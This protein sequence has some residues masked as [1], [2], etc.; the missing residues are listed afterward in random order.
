MF[1]G[2]A[3]RVVG[4]SREHS[5]L[6]DDI[7]RELEDQDKLDQ[8]TFRVLGTW[9]VDDRLTLNGFYFTQDSEQGNGFAN[10]PM[11]FYRES[12][13]TGVIESAF[14]GTNFLL[15]YEFDNFTFQSSSNYQTKDVLLNA[16]GP[17]SVGSQ[18]TGYP[19]GNGG[20]NGPGL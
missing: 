15:S 6:Y 14:S 20:H 9:Q 18:Q 2:A 11:G 7:D 13:G 12:S 3:L 17:V 8:T 19:D 16:L 5:G 4:V 10:N 1:D